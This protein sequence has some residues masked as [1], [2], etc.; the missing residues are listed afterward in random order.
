[1]LK[2]YR[3]SCHC[4]GVTFECD[5]DLAQGTSR[6]NCS[7]CSKARYWMAFAKGP[8]LRVLKGADLLTDYQHTPAGMAEPFLH[9]LFCSRCGVRPFTRGGYLPAFGDSFHAVNL[10]CLDDAYDDLAKAPVRH[11]DGRHDN[12]EATPAQP[13]L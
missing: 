11:V 7:F 5:L 9:F 13:Q 4:Q 10:A 8:T 1:M 12:Y 2:T 6:C 3:G